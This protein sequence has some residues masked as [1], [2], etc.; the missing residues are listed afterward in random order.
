MARKNDRYI[1]GL[2]I[3]YDMMSDPQND[4]NAAAKPEHAGVI[5]S[6]G[7]QLRERFPVQEFKEPTVQ[8]KAKGQGRNKQAIKNKAA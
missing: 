4:L 2:D 6:M 7:R 5:E 1:T 3:G 8:P